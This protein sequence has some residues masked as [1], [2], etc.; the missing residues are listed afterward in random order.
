MLNQVSIYGHFIKRPILANDLFDDI[1]LKTKR[2]LTSLKQSKIFPKEEIVIQPG[3]S[4]HFIFILK[5][6]KAEVVFKNDLSGKD[7][8]RIIEKKEIVGLRQLFTNEPCEICLKTL[9]TCS[10][11]LIRHADFIEFL[12]IHISFDMSF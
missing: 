5:K 7:Q 12:K 4:P 3:D 9:T 11:E 2:S 10:F 8:K 1:S 6:G